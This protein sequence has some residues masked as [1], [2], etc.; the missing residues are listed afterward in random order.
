[1]PPG[2]Y[3]AGAEQTRRLL[4]GSGDRTLD[5]DDPATATEYF[6]ALFQLVDTDA[7]G[8]QRLRTA[9]DYPE[10]DR[11][12]RMIDD[13]ME[14]LVVTFGTPDVRRQVDEV[15]DALMSSS[16][17]GRSLLRQLQPYLVTVRR[18]S[19]ERYRREGM[20]E[21]V[22]PGIGRWLGRYDHVLGL[23]DGQLSAEA[24]VV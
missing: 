23:V 13:D 12:F 22:L 11:R 5:P 20:I 14:S 9:L 2:D 8:I 4:V 15:V 18:R 1:M 7:N 17:S 6:R 10:V 3:R 24:L 16:G 19:A 21:P